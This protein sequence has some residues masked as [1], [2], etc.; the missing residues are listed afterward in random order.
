VN[1]NE[2]VPEPR[3]VILVLNPDGKMLSSNFKPLA[4][5]DSPPEDAMLPKE[6]IAV[7]VKLADD[8]TVAMDNAWPLIVDKPRQAGPGTTK[9]DGIGG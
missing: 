7:N 6:S 2:Y 4:E 5:N 8:P 9:M 1:A 3:C